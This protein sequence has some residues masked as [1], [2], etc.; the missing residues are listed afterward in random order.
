[1]CISIGT[2]YRTL[3]CRRSKG[4]KLKRDNTTSCAATPNSLFQSVD[5]DHNQDIDLAEYIGWVAHSQGAQV[6]DNA[7]VLDLWIQKFQA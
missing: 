3:G 5:D 6:V 7:T 2:T 1:M 4:S